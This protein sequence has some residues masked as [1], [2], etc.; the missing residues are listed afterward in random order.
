[1]IYLLSLFCISVASTMADRAVA[2]V[3]STVRRAGGSLFYTADSKVAC[4]ENRAMLRMI[5]CLQRALRE[6]VLFCEPENGGSMKETHLRKI[7]DLRQ[8][9]KHAC[10]AL[11]ALSMFFSPLFAD[12]TSL[13]AFLV[14]CVAASCFIKLYELSKPVTEPG[15]FFG[16][17]AA[18]PVQLLRTLRRDCRERQQA[19][20]VPEDLSSAYLMVTPRFFLEFGGLERNAEVVAV[21]PLAPLPRDEELLP[22]DAPDKICCISCKIRKRVRVF[23]ACGHYGVCETCARASD[24]CPYC[25]AA[26]GTTVFFDC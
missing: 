24:R 14:T 9:V 10:F 16:E 2:S 15:Q 17:W 22:L 3:T 7:E 23:T 1:M 12:T 26:S 19:L 18:M 25:R 20:A 8:L 21:V 4:M 6:P 5:L 11:P 13:V